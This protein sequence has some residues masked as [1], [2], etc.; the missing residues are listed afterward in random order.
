MRNRVMRAGGVP[1][2]CQFMPQQP[3]TLYTGTPPQASSIA[4]HQAQ[5][6]GVL[7]LSDFIELLD[8]EV[9]QVCIVTT[10]VPIFTLPLEHNQVAAGCW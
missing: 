1:E 7:A 6:S 2:P 3:L 10:G 8:D 5:Q 4:C 9:F